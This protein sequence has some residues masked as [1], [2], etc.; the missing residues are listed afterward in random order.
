MY[1]HV[2]MLF[3]TQGVLKEQKCWM[4]RSGHIYSSKCLYFNWVIC[5]WLNLYK[6]IP[7]DFGFFLNNNIKAITWWCLKHS[8]FQGC[9][10]GNYRLLQTGSRWPLYSTLGSCPLA[11][12]RKGVW[13]H[14]FLC[15]PA[16][17][18]CPQQNQGVGDVMGREGHGAGSERTAGPKLRNTPGLSVSPGCL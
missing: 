8:L 6:Q 9:P 15:P 12:L 1:K 2:S 10:D 18:L 3:L 17:G 16:F 7:R 11:D 14:C 4:R 5:S 13:L